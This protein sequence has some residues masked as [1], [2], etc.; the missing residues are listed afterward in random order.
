MDKILIA[1]KNK[2]KF[3][4]VKRIL[5]TILENCEYYSLYDLNEIVKDEKEIGNVQQRAYAKAKQVYDNIKEN[6]FMYIIGIDDGIEMKGKII[7]N[8]KEYINDIIEDRYLK[9]GEIVSV[10]RAYCFMNIH[11]NYKTVTTKIPFEYKKLNKKIEIKQ[12][13][14]PLS[15]VLK[16]LDS[17]KTVVEMEDNESNEYYLKYSKSVIE[18]ILK[19]GDE[20]GI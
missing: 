10:V 11:G 12:N 1:T 14:Y 15:N 3:E 18:E 13:S 20:N 9:E 17:N 8:V 7:E 4:I 6:E 19:M 16:P 2:D 5:N